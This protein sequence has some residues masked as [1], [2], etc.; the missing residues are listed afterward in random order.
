VNNA[1]IGWSNTGDAI[2][3]T[4]VYGVKRMVEAF[5]PMLDTSAGR[6]VNLGSGAG[7]M[8]VKSQDKSTVTFLSTQAVTW[9]E[10][11]TYMKTSMPK[12]QGFGAYGLSK[13]VMHRLTELQAK[14]HPNLTIS[15]VSPGYVQT[16]MTGGGGNLT[17]DQGA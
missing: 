12:Q 4:N 9:A 10:L 15:V 1:G 14:E 13:A 11:E 3:A 6:V 7:P 16:N 17:P 5:V 2:M 8:F